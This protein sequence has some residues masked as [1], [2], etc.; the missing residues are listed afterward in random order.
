MK[1]NILKILLKKLGFHSNKSKMQVFQSTSLGNK[2][3]SDSGNSTWVSVDANKQNIEKAK[4]ADSK[5]F[6]SEQ[7][8]RMFENIDDLVVYI[9]RNLTIKYITPSI[10][11]FLGYESDELFDK[12]FVSLLTS[13]K[14]SEFNTAIER[15]ESGRNK[16]HLFFDFKTKAGIV[17]QAEMLI[18]KFDDRKMGTG[19]LISSR[20]IFNRNVNINIDETEIDQLLQEKHDLQQELLVVQGHIRELQVKLVKLSEAQPEDGNADFTKISRIMLMFARDLK[21]KILKKINIQ[22]KNTHKIANKYKDETMRK[23]DLEEYFTDM[24]SLSVLNALGVSVLEKRLQLYSFLL[25]RNSKDGV[26]LSKNKMYLKPILNRIMDELRDVCSNLNFCFDI[27]GDDDIFVNASQEMFMSVIYNILLAIME[28]ENGESID[29]KNYIHF[30]KYDNF[31]KLNIVYANEFKFEFAEINYSEYFKE[32][33]ISSKEF[34]FNSIYELCKV[35]GL[36]IHCVNKEEKDETDISK[37]LV[38]V[39]HTDDV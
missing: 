39:F 21:Y 3:V 13:D 33:D 15:L 35:Q 27:I 23:F 17:K 26:D 7:L 31:V 8:L 9:D 38:I 25:D 16:M 29:I 37:E 34:L 22:Y 1:E 10:K 19:Y 12:K 28:H 36:S 11:D 32:A 6:T 14:F 30:E 5:K 18:K 24:H 20:A 4:A 2:D